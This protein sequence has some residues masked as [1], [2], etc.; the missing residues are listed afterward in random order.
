MGIKSLLAA[1]GG[2]VSTNS[3]ELYSK[4]KLLRGQAVDP[5][6]SYW[7]IDIGYNYR[8]T[9]MQAAIGLAQLENIDWHM[10][11]RQKV[12]DWYKKYLSDMGDYLSMQAI[13][14]HC[15]SAYWMSNVILSDKVIMERDAVMARMTECGIEMR[16]VFYP[17]H[18]M[19]PYRSEEKF[20]VAEKISSRG[21]SLP[22]HAMLTEKQIEYICMC[23]KNIIIK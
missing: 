7:H 13:P 16:P 6:K 12:A 14:K 3:E 22:S 23:L 4:M 2:A 18:V 1:R 21:F 19:P 9:N 11:Q 8:M 20:P 10:A 17:M 5:N 15:K